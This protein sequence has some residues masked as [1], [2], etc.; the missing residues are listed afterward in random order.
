[1]K[2]LRQSTVA[3]LALLLAA[4]C[5]G[6]SP[7]SRVEGSWAPVEEADEASPTLV[8]TFEDGGT[9]TATGSDA[10][11]RSEGTYTVSDQGRVSM[12]FDQGE[13]QATLT[14]NG[15]TLEVAFRGRTGKM[16]RVEP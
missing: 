2:A 11:D 16:V 1:M 5:G 8:L 12:T 6:T 9:V 10:D 7:E 4:A 15:D 13:M 3:V 14:E